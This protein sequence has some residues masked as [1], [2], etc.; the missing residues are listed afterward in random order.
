MRK[1]HFF[2]PEDAF[3]SGGKGRR[4]DLEGTI[5]GKKALFRGRRASLLEGGAPY[6]LRRAPSWAKR[7]PFRIRRATLLAGRH[8]YNAFGWPPLTPSMIIQKRQVVNA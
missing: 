1:A 8:P 3:A 5:I 4:F 7:V 6:L 2:V